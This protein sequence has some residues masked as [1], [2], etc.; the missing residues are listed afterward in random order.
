MLTH[1]IYAR[2]DIVTCLIW[3]VL[4]PAAGKAHKSETA[5]AEQ[6]KQRMWRNGKEKPVAN[7]N[8]SLK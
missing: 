1:G 6:Q 3:R 7:V 8:V 4:R 5:E 2:P